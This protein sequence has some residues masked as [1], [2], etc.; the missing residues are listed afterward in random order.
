[1]TRTYLRKKSYYTQFRFL[2]PGDR[3]RFDPAQNGPFVK[4]NRTSYEDA[5]VGD[6][7]VL[8]WQ[9]A[10]VKKSWPVGIEPN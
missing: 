1:M 7:T 5:R 9:N 4:F 10:Y 6:D 3:F 2:K 8:A